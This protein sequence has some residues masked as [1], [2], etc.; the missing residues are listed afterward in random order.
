MKWWGPNRAMPVHQF[1]HSPAGLVEPGERKLMALLVKKGLDAWRL[2]CYECQGV[3]GEDLLRNVERVR[4][5]F[6]N[7]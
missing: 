2:L 5:K 7:L 6:I 1:D 3:V 4:L